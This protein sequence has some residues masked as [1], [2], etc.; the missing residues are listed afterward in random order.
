MWHVGGECGVERDSTLFKTVGSANHNYFSGSTPNGAF[1]TPLAFNPPGGVITSLGT[2][3]VSGV[4]VDA[5]GQ[6][7]ANPPGTVTVNVS[8]IARATLPNVWSAYCSGTTTIQ[9]P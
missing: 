7:L 6:P 8:G 1:R 5:N 9:V 3:T 2:A 4:Q